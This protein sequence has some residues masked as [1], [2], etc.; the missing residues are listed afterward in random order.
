MSPTAKLRKAAWFSV[1]MASLVVLMACDSASVSC[2]NI[3]NL[4]TNMGLLNTEGEVLGNLIDLDPVSKNAG[5]ASELK[6]FDKVNDAETN[7]D[8]DEADMDTSSGLDISFSMTLTAAE[9]AALSS[10]LA[11]NVQ[12]KLTNSNRHQMK[13]PAAVIN[14]PENAAIISGYMHPGHHL[15]LVVAGNTSE[16]AQFTTKNSA[17]NKIALNLPGG[18]AFNVTVNYQ[19]QDSLA[20]TVSKDRAASALTFFKVV[21]IVKAQD[22]SY[23][24][25][26]LVEPLNKYNLSNALR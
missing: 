9:T 19:C 23:T 10:E 2:G 26:P 15:V 18:K 25:Q 14:R 13:L 6:S 4:Q 3:S 5:Y 17:N 1:A 8:S 22:G 16:S 7:P 20:E 21:E 12:L 11:S 24:T